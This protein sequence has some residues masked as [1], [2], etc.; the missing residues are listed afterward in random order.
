MVLRRVAASMVAGRR[1]MRL[2]CA[3]WRQPSWRRVGGAERRKC[4]PLWAGEKRLEVEACCWNRAGGIF[5]G[6]HP[7]LRSS[8]WSE[9]ALAPISLLERVCQ[10][11]RVTCPAA[12]ESL[13]GDVCR[14]C[15]D[16]ANRG[17]CVPLCGPFAGETTRGHG[18]HSRVPAG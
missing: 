5:D 16:E 18:S 14:P 1:P 9:R 4:T 11:G 6:F 13:A 3:E 10:R 8:P 2:P 15:V 17:Q 12:G 7:S